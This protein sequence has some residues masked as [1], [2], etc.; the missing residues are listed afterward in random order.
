MPDKRLTPA[1]R[2]ARAEARSSPVPVRFSPDE[3]LQLQLAAALNFQPVSEFVRA[4]VLLA[5]NDF[6]DDV[7]GNS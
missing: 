1:G 6:L 2:K 3:R 4:V 7:D 5:A